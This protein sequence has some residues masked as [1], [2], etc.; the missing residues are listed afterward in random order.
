M[1]FTHQKVEMILVKS[2]S[3]K[4]ELIRSHFYVNVLLSLGCS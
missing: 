4:A 2:S 1:Y 3:R